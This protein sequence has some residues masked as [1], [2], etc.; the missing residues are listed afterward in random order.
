MDPALV[1]LEYPPDG[2]F[3]MDF[4]RSDDGA[5]FGE[6]TVIVP[7]SRLDPPSSY[8]DTDVINGVNNC[9]LTPAHT[10]RIPPHRIGRRAGLLPARGDDGD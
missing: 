8:N 6:W 7:D 1:G 3:E 9:R 4:R 2:M 10:G 5:A